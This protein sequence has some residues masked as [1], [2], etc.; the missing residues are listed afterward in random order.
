MAQEVM[1]PIADVPGLVEKKTGWKPSIHTIR[2]WAGDGKTTARKIGGRIFVDA[3]S[4]DS[5]FN[6]KEDR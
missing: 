5:M 1:I 6:G 4:L 3:N 2:D